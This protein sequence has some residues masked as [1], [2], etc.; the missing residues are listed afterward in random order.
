M[1]LDSGKLMYSE[2]NNDE[3][4]TPFYAVTPILKYIPKDAKVWCPF[5]TIDSQ[6]VKQI[7]KQN[8]VVFTHINYGQDFL[9]YEPSEWDVIV[10]NPP[11]TNKRKFFERALSFEKPFALIMTNTW[12]NDSAPK[13]L[14]KDKDLQLLMFDKRMKFNSPDGRPNDKITFSSSYYCWNF[15]PKQI[16]ME[17]LNIP[18]SNS[19][20]K[21]PI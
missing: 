1:T 19:N 20:A 16:V 2:G 7:S 3:C 10:S 13:Q 18:K 8:E 11:F 6:F 17:E 5:D 21:L 15:L 9:T 12:L 4:Y 14:F